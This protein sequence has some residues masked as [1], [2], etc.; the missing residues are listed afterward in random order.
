MSCTKKLKPF[1]ILILGLLCVFMSFLNKSITFAVTGSDEYAQITSNGYLYKAPST[2]QSSQICMLEKSYF[3]RIILTHDND[4]FLVTYAGVEGYVLKTNVRK[5]I[6]KPKTEYPIASL[7]TGDRCFLRSSPK[8]LDNNIVATLPAHT[9][10]IKYIGKIIGSEMMD[11][12][13]TTWYFVEYHNL[14][15]YVYGWYLTHAPSITPNVEKVSFITDEG[16]IVANPLSNQT[17]LF[18]I[19]LTLIPAVFIL[20]MLFKKPTSKV[21]SPKM[22]VRKPNDI[23]YDALL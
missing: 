9:T 4:F 11:F 3:V 15:G 18:V 13:G 8:R 23:D 22:A 7:S 17:S 14:R 6:E 5:V 19:I 2:A 21:V 16:Y 12:G 20:I 10:N 1:L